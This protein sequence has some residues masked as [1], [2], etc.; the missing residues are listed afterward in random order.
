MSLV[1]VHGLRKSYHH[2]I[3]ERVAGEREYP[4]LKGIDFEIDAGDFVGDHG[5]F[6]LWEDDAVKDHGNARSADKGKDLLR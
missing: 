1:S 2:S 3:V 6:W 4:V 5:A